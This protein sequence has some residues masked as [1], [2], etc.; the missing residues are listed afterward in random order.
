M[1]K[2]SEA[3]DKPKL[4]PRIKKL[5]LDALRSGKY[6]QAEGTLRKEDGSM[7]CLGVLC[8][9]I[10]QDQ[11]KGT[12]PKLNEEQSYH[13]QKFVFRGVGPDGLPPSTINTLV[14]MDIGNTEAKWGDQSMQLSAWNDDEGKSFKQI[15]QIIEKNF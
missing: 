1:S 12:W 5:W 9:V 4:K 8:E 10:R 11:K 2:S 3:T 15:A 14:G 13:H 6:K 7:C